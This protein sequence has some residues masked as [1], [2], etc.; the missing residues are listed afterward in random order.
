MENSAEAPI[1]E[2][3]NADRDPIGSIENS[4]KSIGELTS[5]T[6]EVEF[7]LLDSQFSATRSRSGSSSSDNTSAVT[8]N[9][10]PSVIK[11]RQKSKPEG[12]LS[13]LKK[14]LAIAKNV[15]VPSTQYDKDDEGSEESLVLVDDETS[16]KGVVSKP[17]RDTQEALNRLNLHT[18][19][20]DE[21][22][23][24]SSDKV[25]S[26]QIQPFEDDMAPNIDDYDDLVDDV[27]Y[28]AIQPGQSQEQ[29]TRQTRLRAESSNP[30]SPPPKKKSRGN[31]G[32][33]QVPRTRGLERNNDKARSSELRLL[34]LMG[35]GTKGKGRR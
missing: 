28:S 14:R 1:V 33:S 25:T 21:I 35:G 31:D 13:T 19:S 12:G 4:Q 34:S 3:I 32:A 18:H 27:D 22:E 5:S 2:Q 8:K 30:Q 10:K 20:G 29:S 6:R 17:T 9:V 15:V 7:T 16:S 23:A 24:P 26:S 11:A